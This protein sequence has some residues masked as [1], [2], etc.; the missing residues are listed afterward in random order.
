MSKASV[1]LRTAAVHVR[2][3]QDVTALLAATATRHGDERV[4]EPDD[5]RLVLQQPAGRRPSRASRAVL[6]HLDADPRPSP[7]AR[8][9][10]VTGVRGGEAALTQHGF[11]LAA[12][13]VV[14]R[15]RRE[16]RRPGSVARTAEEPAA[17]YAVGSSAVVM[18][19]RWRE[20]NPRPSSH[21]QGFSGCSLSTVFS[22]PAISQARRCRA[23]S[24]ESP[25][26]PDDEGGEQWLSSRCQLPGREHSRADRPRYSL[27]RRVRGRC[28]WNRH[29]LVYGVVVNELT[30]SPR[31][32]S[33]GSTFDVETCHPHVE[34]SCCCP[35]ATGPTPRSPRAFPIRR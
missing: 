1:S 34:L 19:W 12:P 35:Q 23:Q 10:L 16:P 4:Q 27:R 2:E 32:A 25:H 6:A 18:G 33:P 13:T 21:P 7:T 14:V 11:D 28:A 5:A 30:P 8:G 15:N 9:E 31:P 17:H 3:H 29:L 24:S 20:S 22:A 26:H